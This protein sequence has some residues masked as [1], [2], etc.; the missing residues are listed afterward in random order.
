[1]KLRS[2]LACVAILA[3]SATHAITT[4]LGGLQPAH[5]YYTARDDLSGPFSDS[6]TFTIA[7]GIGALYIQWSDAF[8]FDFNVGSP[9]G[10]GILP[11]AT[12]FDGVF[13]QEL[14]PNGEYGQLTLNFFGHGGATFALGNQTS[15]TPGQYF[16]QVTAVPEAST[17]FMLIIGLGFMT[18]RLKRTA[19]M[20]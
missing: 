12:D 8:D 1:M 10:G 7:K 16:V 9:F 17:W 18:W 6:L 15:F 5:V 19:L 13:R 14:N 11:P 2:V 20:Q 3:S 4:D